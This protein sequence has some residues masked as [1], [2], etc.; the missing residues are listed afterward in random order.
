MATGRLEHP[1]EL[2]DRPTDAEADMPKA[3]AFFYVCAG[4]FLR[5]AWLLPA[6]S[7]GG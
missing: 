3:R 5:R 1:P 7:Q 4:I 2:A 6:S